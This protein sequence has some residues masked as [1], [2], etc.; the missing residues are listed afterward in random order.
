MKNLILLF[1]SVAAIILTSCSNQENGRFNLNV[2]QNGKSHRANDASI[3]LTKAPFSFIFSVDSIENTADTNIR[4]HYW[5]TT[6]ESQFEKFKTAKNLLDVAEGGG[7]NMCPRGNPDESIT[8]NMQYGYSALEINHR[9][10]GATKESSFNNVDRHGDRL[11][12]WYGVKN[13][14]E[15]KDNLG[16][17]SIVDV[18]GNHLMIY[19]S[20]RGKGGVELEGRFVDIH[21][22]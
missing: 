11:D 16:Q 18:P 22:E 2:H 6:D 15:A 12:A 7:T 17:I 3:K 19:F 14:Y 9:N 21:F 13:V 8:L 5:A 20:M 1:C 10:D 4:F